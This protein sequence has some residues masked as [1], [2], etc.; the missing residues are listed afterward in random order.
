MSIII[1]AVLFSL[2]CSPVRQSE[3]PTV[4]PTRRDVAFDKSLIGT[5]DVATQDP[6]LV[7]DPG[8]YSRFLAFTS[9]GMSY[10][11]NE[12]D[13]TPR[14]LRWVG[15]I[16]TVIPKY[17]YSVNGNARIN[18]FASLTRPEMWQLLEASLGDAQISALCRQEGLAASS[19]DG[20][21]RQICPRPARRKS[22]GRSVP[23]SRGLPRAVFPSISSAR[24]MASLSNP[25]L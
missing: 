16:S 21:Q 10:N 18:P 14:L 8:D 9:I 4:V 3:P 12:A 25:V 20:Q 15:G 23:Y 17:I 2:I 1:P 24:C 7:V 22:A 13:H 11:E 19:L 6:L 5:W